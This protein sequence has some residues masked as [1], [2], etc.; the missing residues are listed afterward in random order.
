MDG[1]WYLY[2]ED[3]L[4]YISDSISEINVLFQ[5]EYNY[6]TEAHDDFLD[7]KY[8]ELKL[9]NE[10]HDLSEIEI[11]KKI[12]QKF[13]KENYYNINL[14]TQH[15]F[16]NFD[17][18]L[19]SIDKHKFEVMDLYKDNTMYTVKFGNASGKLC[20]AVDQSLEAIK[21]YKKGLINLPGVTIKEVCLWL[22][23]E[24]E[25]LPLLNGTPNINAMNMLILKNKIDLWKKEVRM[26]GFIPSIRI[27]YYS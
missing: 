20:Y 8:E 6:S 27:N 14:E 16:T 12:K 18:T 26:M 25:E 5:P 3:Y 23:L 15:H 22:V 4:E 24:R 7:I 21:A 19:I 13:Y 10:Y 17:R 1:E 2:N 11:R 9:A